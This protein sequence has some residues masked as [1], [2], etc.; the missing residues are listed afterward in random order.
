MKVPSWYTPRMRKIAV[1]LALALSGFALFLGA[2]R[3][4]L[5][6]GA[7]A[8]VAPLEVSRLRAE[9]DAEAGRTR[10]LALLSPT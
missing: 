6:V 2:S 8:H 5:L 3:L 4:P 9:F 10:V 7:R 1:V